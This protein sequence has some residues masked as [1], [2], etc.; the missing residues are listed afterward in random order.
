M[1]VVARTCN[2]GTPLALRVLGVLLWVVG[3]FD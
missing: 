2:H 3:L 1:R